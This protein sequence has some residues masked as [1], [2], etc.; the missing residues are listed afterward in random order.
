MAA[1][2][3]RQASLVAARRHRREQAEVRRPAVRE[4]LRADD[5]LDGGQPH[6]PCRLA[7][8]AHRGL[9]RQ[10]VRGIGRHLAG[11]DRC[12]DLVLADGSE[13]GVRAERDQRGERHDLGVRGKAA[14]QDVLGPPGGPP[15]R[16]ARPDEPVMPVAAQHGRRG[17]PG[18]R[19]PTTSS[20]TVV[21]SLPLSAASRSTSSIPPISRATRSSASLCAAAAH[22][23]IMGDG[24]PR[25]PPISRPLQTLPDRGLREA[26]SLSD[27]AMP[28]AAT[29]SSRCETLDVPGIGS[30]TGE[31]CS[32]R[33]G[34]AGRGTR[35][36]W[37]RAP[38]GLPGSA[39]SPVAS[40]NHGMNLMPLAALKSR[41]SSALRFATL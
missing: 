33:P 11:A 37:R 12:H 4:P 7:G 24:G 15:R 10:R 28:A 13:R 22:A 16:P 29:L 36:A 26:Y 35:R 5:P 27:S 1:P 20:I 19:R 2:S 32:S 25:A 18:A 14:E 38:R 41:S 8:P 31:R 40:G 17:F 21:K 23:L 30:M 34:P 6:G 39:R 9:Q 3:N